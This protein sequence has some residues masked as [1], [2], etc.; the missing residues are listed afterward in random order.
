[1]KVAAPSHQAHERAQ[2]LP[3]NHSPQSSSTPSPGRDNPKEVI[4]FFLVKMALK[5]EPTARAGDGNGE[6]GEAMAPN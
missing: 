5:R 2:L 1:M 4:F 3:T 6:M